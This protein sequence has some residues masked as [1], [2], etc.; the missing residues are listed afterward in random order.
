M[1]RDILNRYIYRGEFWRGIFRGW[2]FRS[3]KTYT[4]LSKMSFFGMK[5]DILEREVFERFN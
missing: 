2:K 3:G 5:K 4:S 1:G